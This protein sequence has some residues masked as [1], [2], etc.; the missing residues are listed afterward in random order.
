MAE[1]VEYPVTL[2]TTSVRESS[3]SKCN[4]KN[5]LPFYVFIFIVDMM[6]RIRKRQVDLKKMKGRTRSYHPRNLTLSPTC[7]VVRSERRHR[8]DGRG[9]LDIRRQT[10][11]PSGMMLV[12]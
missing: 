11:M 4:L 1:W 3:E 7:L 8:C 5:V 9:P 10:V 2:V 12:R 6:S